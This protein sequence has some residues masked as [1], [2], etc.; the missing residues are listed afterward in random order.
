MRTNFYTLLSALVLSAF[1]LYPTHAQDTDLFMTT[2]QATSSNPN[3]LIIVDN[4][5]SNNG[6]L[7]DT[8]C[9]T[10]KKLA[11]EQCVL[12]NLINSTKINS[13]INVGLM[14]FTPSGSTKGGYV[15]YAIRPMTSA[16]KATLITAINSIS[17]SNNAPYATTMH[18]AYLYY[19]G[20]TPY[21]GTTTSLYDHAAVSSGAYVSPATNT[22]QKNYIIFLGNGGPDSSENGT[23]QSLL[24][25]DKGMSSS[26]LTPITL[27]TCCNQFQQN[28]LDEFAQFFNGTDVATNVAGTQDLTVYTILADDST[29]TGYSSEK[30]LL[31]SAASQGG[32]IKAYEAYS[33]SALT[34]A[35]G[36][37][38]DRI[39][40]VNSVFAAVT[41]P[42][43]VNVRGTNLDQVYMG[44][45]R[46][47]AN[48]LPRW[49][50]N[51]KEYQLKVTSAGSVYLA[52]ST[53]AVAT[54]TNTDAFSSS[55]I[56]YWTNSST[57]WSYKYLNDP[58]YATLKSDSPDGNTAEKGASAQYLRTAFATAQ[59]ARKLYTCTGACAS[60]SSL[61]SYPFSTSNTDITT[62]NTGTSSATDLQNLI[63]WTRGTDIYDENADGSTS[64]V[65]A[66]IHSDV[67][68]SRPAVVNYNRYSDDDDVFVFYGANDG[69]FHAIQGGKIT[70]TGSSRL[71]G[72]EQWGFIPS[73][74]F[75]NLKTIRDNTTTIDLDT[76]HNPRSPD[77]T[78]FIDGPIG[79]YQLDANSDGKYNTSDNDKV[80]LY[81]AMRR[82]GRFLYAL[83][84]SDPAAVKYLWKKSNSST[85][86]TELGQTWST[87]KPITM[88]AFSNPVII[89]GG[90]YDSTAEDSATS[91]GQATAQGTATMG[92]AIMVID[93]TD[94]TLLW[95]AGP[96]PSGATTN[97]TVAGMTY[98]IP[99]DILAIDRDKDGKVDRLYAV[100]T[101]A[102]I[103]RVDCDDATPSNWVVTKIASLG[104]TGA[105]ARKFLY[106]PDVVYVSSSSG[107]SQTYDGIFIGSGDREHPFDTTVT[108]RFY[109]I[110]DP[111]IGKSVSSFTTITESD[112]YDTTSN[113]IQVGTTSQQTTAQTAMN[114]A[115][116][117]YVTLNSGEKVV[118]NAV[119]VSGGVY[120]G[121]NQPAS[122]S[123]DS[124]TNLGTARNYTVD[125]LNGGAMFDYNSDG[126]LASSDR[127]NT[128]TGGGFP[129]PP[130]PV[131]IIGDDGNPYRAV[132]SGRTVT[133]VA[134]SKPGQRYRTY[135]H[136]ER[137]N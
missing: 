24:A 131:T 116:G 45:F 13:N 133:K 94:G 108:N 57:Y 77:K 49:F 124:C 105:S 20:A 34:I 128:V 135:W 25:T 109:M 28:W 29:K 54:V 75:G 95:Q 11:M 68:H 130:V 97:K 89:M 17:T 71:G 126:T 7:T 121:T 81:L 62:S 5:G 127:S 50:G 37:A 78:Y 26:S 4:A 88:R 2:N 132:V 59:S 96:S 118:G 117:W 48:D 36:D 60:G 32:T 102:N 82:G 51:L 107:S 33:S 134:G 18:E 66:S 58:D 8:A 93:A 31:D 55:A 91:T 65:R 1:V 106:A 19:K 72:T 74:F 14:I 85:G 52:D 122:A 35:V 123:S 70:T 15:L 114:S 39:Q 6:N 22:C 9:S 115:K 73:E 80:Y 104:G 119:V 69:I 86:Y 16:N 53:G 113:L 103:W 129:A 63:N 137:D 98:D 136:N 46:P 99:A 79:V 61:S 111:N 101:G 83:N 64:D 120:F 12:V 43:S 110:K 90:G 76:T 10:T 67:L 125:F 112:L 3:V 84:V 41:L 40:A 100:D 30:A 42:V 92:R 27:P 56:S 44:I 47:D 21:A 38:I 87:P 23:A